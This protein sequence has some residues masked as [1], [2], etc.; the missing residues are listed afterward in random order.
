MRVPSGEPELVRAGAAGD[1]AALAALWDAYGARVFAFCQRVLGRA[2]AAADAAQDAFLL[3]H[4]ELGRLASTG[5]SFGGAVFRAARTTCHDLLARDRAPGGARRGPA[6]S[7]SAAAARLRPQQR[8]ALA[9]S[10]LERLRY[11]EIAAALGIGTEAVGA[12][13]ARARLRLHDELHG[14]ALAAAA[15]RSPDCEDVLALLAA[16]SD[17]ELGPSDAGWADPHVASCP[18]CPRTRRAMDEAAATYAA[19][20]PGIPPSWLRG[21]TLAEL[22]AEA[23]ASAA[24]AAAAAAGTLALGGAGWGAAGPAAASRRAGGAWT[25]P[26]PRLS[27]ALLGAS[28]LAVACAA[29]ALTVSGSLRQRD[30]LSGGA[31]LPDAARSLRVAGVPA[32]PAKHQ[33]R[34][35]QQAPRR[36]RPTRRRH[37]VSFVA[38]RAVR[39]V[40]SASLPSGTR[41]VT[42]TAPRRPAARPKRRRGSR[43]PATPT[44]TPVPASPPPAAPAAPAPVTADA[45]ADELPGASSSAAGDALATTAQVPA[46]VTPLKTTA[47]PQTP[48][49]PAAQPAASDHDFW[50]GP[51]GDQD[52]GDGPSGDQDHGGGWRKGRPPC[53]PAPRCQGRSCRH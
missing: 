47:A 32:A 51:G 1:P 16:A 19:W 4:A 52:D 6:P 30:P 12:L 40:P 34:A 5:E 14:T 38:V 20:S 53:P 43:P 8:A 23:P 48:S 11:A 24:A 35:Q 49:I 26:R 10:G 50:R 18:S 29:L 13:L 3:A 21:A 37:E 2:D 39:R 42:G 45:P 22:G 9:L 25:T 41:G 28:L 46:A 36:T 17:G 15:V 31:R 44:P 33:A 7:L 27:A